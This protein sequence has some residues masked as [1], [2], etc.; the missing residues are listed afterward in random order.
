M[1][2]KSRELAEQKFD[3]NKVNNS[4]INELNKI[5]NEKR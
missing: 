2:L 5:K 3:I 1:G 4:Y